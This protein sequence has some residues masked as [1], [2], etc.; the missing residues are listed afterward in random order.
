MRVSVSEW[1]LERERVM[2]LSSSIVQLAPKSGEE[3]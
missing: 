2:Q 3:S 1:S